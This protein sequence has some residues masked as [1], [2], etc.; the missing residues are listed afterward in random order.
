MSFSPLTDTELHFTGLSAA[1]GIGFGQVV[2][3]VPQVRLPLFI[4]VLPH[5][6]TMEIER[7]KRAMKH[8]RRH[9]EDV[10]HHFR[11][12]VGQGFAY[13]LDPYILMLDDAVLTQTIEDNIHQ[14][15]INAEWAVKRAVEF[16][17]ASFNN[18]QDPYLSQRR[19]DIRDVG[20]RLISILSGQPMGMPPLNGPSILFAEDILPT[21]LAEANPTNLNGLVTDTGGV[22]THTAIIARSLGIPAVFGVQEALDQAAEGVTCI[23]DGSHGEVILHPR[24]ATQTMYLGRRAAEQRLRREG[25]TVAR[26]PAVTR[27]GVACHLLANVEIQSELP[28]VERCGAQSIGLFRS[29]FIVPSDGGALPDEDT[30]YAAYQAVIA[31][32]PDHTAT[33][34]TFDFSSDTLPNEVRAVEPNPAL[35]LHGVRWWLAHEDLAKTQLRAIVRAA[36]QGHVRILLPR[37]TC[38]TELRAAREL[39]LAVCRELG[40]AE[41]LGKQLELGAMIEIP[42]AVFIADRLARESDFLSIGSNDLVQ[43]MLAG[44]RGN[45]RV[46]YLQQPLHPAILAGLNFVVRAAQEAGKPLT[47][48]G[49]MATQPV[50]AFA[51][52]GLGIRHFSLSPTALPQLKSTLRRLSVRDAEQFIAQALNLDTAHD[53]EACAQTY[54]NR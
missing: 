54:L 3:L 26:L 39:L 11:E 53:I 41:Q 21:M 37:L 2:R 12:Q 16:L 43:Y 35:G 38:V 31:A 28:G 40:A 8:A 32:S 24:R 9:L 15:R 30:Q 13:L 45:E 22:M 23:V 17:L 36:A 47:M 50:C 25:L 33:I 42:A 27:D 52:L 14:H 4:H 7:V 51:L 18:P 48:C 5:R 1:P 20:Q 6:V 10:K 29:E 46:S 49:E 34:R 44:D 19:D